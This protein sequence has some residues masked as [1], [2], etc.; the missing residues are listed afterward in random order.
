[1]LLRR[2]KRHPLKGVIDMAVNQS[3][4]RENSFDSAVSFLSTRLQQT[5]CF[6]PQSLTA[7]VS[8]IRLRLGQPVALGGS[9]GIRFVSERKGTTLLPG[10]ESLLTEQEDL[11]ET[12]H[13]LCEY[14]V[15]SCQN[16]ISEGFLTVRG[17]HRAGL[18]GTAVIQDGQITGMRSVSGISLRIARE[19]PGAAD[20]LVP[21]A[22][23]GGLLLTGAP[24]SGKTT[25]L[26]DLARQLSGGGGHAPHTVAVVDERGELAGSWQGERQTD[27]GPCCDVLDGYP[28]AQGILQAIRTLSPEFII[29]DE[30]GAAAEAQALEE[31]LNAGAV[32]VVSA[33]AGSKEELLR[34]AA[35]LRLLRSGAFQS[36]VM[37]GGGSARGSIQKIF[38]AGDLLVESSR[39]D[40]ALPD[41]RN[42]RSFAV[43]QA[44]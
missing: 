3:W 33:H 23:S 9:E 35:I 36:V 41:L 30:V 44:G 25:M 20:A 21:L 24:G 4:L 26:R 43:P 11:N 38:R 6:L 19:I 10:S 8:E 27:L 22:L 28:K 31:G 16:Q 42:G 13:R 14:S 37:L 32:M 34:R 1:M 17:G 29:C 7:Q 40:S 39:I 15:H 5:L 2:A 18:C 12:F